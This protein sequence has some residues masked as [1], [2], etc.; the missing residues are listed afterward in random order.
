MY[1]TLTPQKKRAPMQYM[2]EM[3]KDNIYI[4]VIVIEVKKQK[5]KGEIKA[6]ERGKCEYKKV[7]I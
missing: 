3:I 6:V 7:Y 5:K 1:F 4:I 2:E